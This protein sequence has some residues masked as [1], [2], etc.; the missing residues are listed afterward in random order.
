MNSKTQ[1][2]RIFYRALAGISLYVPCKEEELGKPELQMMTN[3]HGE[4]F[5]PAFYGKRSLKGD[6]EENTLVEFA[7][8]LLR[9]LVGGLPQSVCGVIIEP[10]DREICLD[11]AVWRSMTFLS[12]P[13]R[14]A[15]ELRGG[16][17]DARVGGCIAHAMQEN[18]KMQ[19]GQTVLR[20]AA[21]QYAL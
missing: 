18:D 16:G 3:E 5:V 20:E 4:C 21:C 1:N 19:D 7:F 8:P 6:Y 13:V 15:E 14:G 2:K 9:N 11:R 12:T 17:T 10:Y